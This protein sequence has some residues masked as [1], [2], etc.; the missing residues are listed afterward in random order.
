M[1][2]GEESKRIKAFSQVAAASVN[3][4]PVQETGIVYCTLE[5]AL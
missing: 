1:K 5:L 3:V 2:Q 4:F